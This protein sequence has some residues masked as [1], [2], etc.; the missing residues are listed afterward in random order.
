MRKKLFLTPVTLVGA[1]AV[2]AIVVTLFLNGQSLVQAQYGDWDG[3]INV[4]HHFGGDALYCVDRNFMVTTQYSDAGTGGFRLLSMAGQ[5]LWFVPAADIAS[6]VSQATATGQAVLVGQGRGT[7][8]PVRI[9]T[10]LIGGDDTFAFSGFDE[11]GKPNEV[12][13]KFCQPDAIV[14][15]PETQGDSSSSRLLC[16]L[17]EVDEYYGSDGKEDDFEDCW[18]RACGNQGK[19]CFCVEAYPD[20]L[21]CERNG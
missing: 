14:P 13:F 4:T 21:F 5:E 17:E 18:E 9:M 15:R 10:Y 7:Y 3:R 20:S 8:G 12:V 19:D 6:A 2:L 16:T 1:V 11:W